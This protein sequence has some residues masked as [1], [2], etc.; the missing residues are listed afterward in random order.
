MGPHIWQTGP[1]WER[2]VRSTPSAAQAPGGFCQPRFMDCLGPTTEQASRRTAGALRVAFAGDLCCV[3]VPPMPIRHWVWGARPSPPIT[4]PLAQ[5]SALLAQL[6][7]SDRHA[8]AE[9]LLRLVGAHVPLAQ[10]TIFAFETGRQPSIVAVGDR[11]RTQDLP[12]IAEAYVDRFHRLDGSAAVMASAFLAAQ[13]AGSVEPRIVLHRQRA[14]DIVHEAYRRICYTQPQVAE[15]LSVM[16][17]FEG[18]RWLSVNFYRGVEHGLFDEAALAVVEAFAPLIVQAVRLHHTGLAMHQALPELLLARLVR[19][20]PAL[21]QR[22]ADVL[23]ALMDGLS[24]PAMAERLGLTQSSAQTY[25]KRVLRKLGVA[26]QRE[27]M[28]LVVRGGT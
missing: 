5:V 20:F 17:L 19:R 11:S 9:T 24:T 15:R 18:R 1:G 27:L 22:D 12:D 28:A 4:L 23:A 7:Q 8:V 21:T 26:G 16:A 10:C 2:L 3:T 14:E 6:G 25:Q 13:K